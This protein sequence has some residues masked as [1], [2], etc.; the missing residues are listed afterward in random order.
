MHANH[1]AVTAAGR[2]SR[3][4]PPRAP[5]ALA[6]AAALTLSAPAT[7]QVA[8][9]QLPTSGS[10]AG[11]T[12]TIQAPSGATQVITQTSN[13]MALTWSSFDVGSA[14]TVR[15]DQPSSSAAVLNLIGGSSA[16]QIFGNLSANG[17]VFLINS[18]GVLFGNTAQVNV[19]GLVASSLSTSAAN[20]MSSNDALDAG[21]STAS[22]INSGTITAAAGSVN[23]IGGQVVNDGTITATAGNI[24]LA[25]ADRVTLN[26]EAGGFGVIITRA[27]QSQLA[28]LAVQNTG[29]LI[30]PGN[31][32]SLQASAASG[33][34]SQLINNSGI[35]SAASL[36][37]AGSDGSVSLVANGATGTAIGGSGSINADTGSIGYSAGAGGIE[38]TGVLTAGDLSATAGRDLLLTGSN[39]IAGIRATV[40]GNLSVTNARS[41]GQASALEVNG[42][43]TFALGSNALTLDN[44]GNNFTG[45]VNITAGTTRIDDGNALT[46]G[47][48]NTGNLTA[49]SNGALNL[50][51]GSV[52]GTLTAVSNNGAII[53]STGSGLT[54]T[55]TSNLQA[56]TGAITLTTGSND[57]QQAVTLGGGATSI[58]DANALTL[59]TLSTGDLTAT[60]TGALNLGSGTVTGTLAASS[61]NGAITQSTVSGLSVTGT[62]NLQAGTG[63]ITLTTGSNDFQQAVTLGGGATSITD[64]NALTLGTLSTGN[65]TANSTGALNLGSGTVNGN[66]TATSNN[67][68]ITQSTV[69]GL[70]VTGIGDVQAGTG[71]ITLTTGSNDFQQAVTLGGGATSITDG[72]A[73]TLGTLSTGNLTATS[74]GALN[75]GSGTVTGTLA[76]SSNNGAITQ[77]AVSGL[78]VTGTSNLQAGTGAITL[79]TGSNDFQQALTLGG[80]ATSITDGNALTLGTLSTGNLTAT[81]TGALNLGSGTVGGAL[82][83]VSNNG[84]I[85]QTGPLNVTGAG[86]INAGSGAIVLN[87]N[88]NDFAGGLGLTGGS[89]NVYDRNNLSITALTSGPNGAVELFSNAT[90]SLS[91]F[92][93]DTGT[94]LL[95][96]ASNGGALSTAGSLRGGTVSL[97]ARDGIGIGHDVDAASLILTTG[98]AAVNQTAGS[99]VVATSTTANTGSGA[100]TLSGAGNNFSGLLT[101]SAGNVQLNDVDGMSLGTVNTGALTVNGNGALN[102]GRGTINGALIANS[103]SGAITQTNALTVTG[104]S[105][106][107]AG[108]GTI[109][110]DNAGNDFQAAVSLTGNGITLR[111]ANALTLG[112]LTATGNGATQVLAGGT[113]TLPTQAIDTGT[114]DLSL[115]SLGGALTTAGTLAGNNVAL[116]ASGA[117]NLA[118]AIQAR[119]TL[120][121]ISDTAAITQTA[122][123]LDA[124]GATTATAAAGAGTIT[125]N[126]TNNDFQ[127]ALSLTGSTVLINDRNALNLGSLGTSALTVAS[128]GNLDLGQGT[129]GGTLTASSNGG[130]IGQSGALTLTGAATLDAGSGAIALSNSDN[131]FQDALALTGTGISVRDRNALR[132]GALTAGAG[133]DVALTAGGGLSLPVQAIDIGSGNLSLTADGGLLGT[134]GELRANQIRLHGG[135]GLNLAHDIT[136]ANSLTLTTNNAAIT[137]TAGAITAGALAAVDAGTGAIALEGSNNDFVA[138]LTLTGTGITVYDANDLSIAS[139]SSGSNSPVTLTA[140]RALSLPMQAIDTGSADLRLSSESGTLLTNGALSGRNVSLNAGA[141]MVL[142]HDVNTSGNLRLTTDNALIAQQSGKA[143]V[144]GTTQIVAG[145]GDVSLTSQ[146]NVFSD[147]VSVS[148]DQVQIDALGALRFGS[149]ATTTLTARSGGALNLG[150]GSTTGT[151]IARSGSGGITQT[152]AVTAGGAATMDAGSATIALNNANNDFQGAVGLAGNGIALTDRNT[153][154]ASS[155]TGNSTGDIALIAQTLNLPASAISAGTGTLSLTAT[156]G[157]FSTGGTLSGGNVVLDARDGLTLAHDI[158]AGNL[159]LRT[160]NAA[161]NQTGGQLTAGGAT[162]ANAG[163]AAIAL[164]GNND[165]QNAVTLTGGAV[166]INDRNALTLSAL[167]TGA[168]TVTSNG[169]LNL[170]QGT[171]NGAL[172]AN[173]TGGAITQT[174]ALNISGTSTLN[175]GGGAIT[176]NNANNDFQGAVGLTGNGIAVTDRNTLSVSSIIG[177]STGDIALTAQTL[178]LPASAISAGTGTLSLTAT[179]SAFSTG[180]N[181]SGGNVVLD[182]RDGLTLAHDINAGNLTLRTTNAAINQTAGQLSISGTTGA[183]AGAA[184]IALTGNNDFQNAVTLTGGAVQINDRNALTLSALNTGALTVTSNGALNLGQGTVNGVLVANSTGGAIT[185]TGALN[186]SGTST[187]NAGTG[188]ITLSNANNDFQGAVG[189]TGNGITVSDT[190]TLS[191]SSISGNTSGNIALTAQTLNLPASAISAGTGTLSLTA[192]A[193]ALGTNG[194]L[195]GGNVVLDAR[196]GLTL[197]NDISANNA[198]TLRTT[199]AAINQTAGQLLVGGATNANAG[200]AAIALTGN[201]DFQSAVTLTGGAVQLN[202]RNALTLG[203]VNT[204]ALTVTSN[205]ALNLGQ[206]T[207][208]GAL[209]A[210]SSNGAITQAGAL[211]INGTI[212]LNAGSSAITLNNA[213]NDFAGAV[214]VAGS[215]IALADRN[216]LQIV[217]L[218]S[219]GNASVLLDAGGALQLPASAIDVG[220]GALSLTARGSALTTTHALRGGDVQLSGANGIALGDDVAASGTLSLRSTNAAITQTAGTLQVA[221]NSVVDAGSGAITLNAAGNDFQGSLA[222]TGGATRVRDTNALSL[223]ALD[224]GALTVASNGALN[225]GF[226]LVDGDLDAASNGGAVTQTGAL[227]VTGTTRINSAGATI[228]LADAGNDFQSALSLSGGDTRVRDRNALALDTLDV[229]ALDVASG[230]GLNLGQGRIGGTLVARSGSNAAGSNGGPTAQAVVRPAATGAD[231]TQQ[232]A[233]TI[234]GNSR[235]DAGTAAIVLTD[236]GNDFQGSVQTSGGS[237]AL[238]DRNDLAAAAQSSGAVNL[239]AGGQLS[240]SGAISGSSVTLGSGGA[241]LLAHDITS[242]GTLSLRSGGAITQRAGSLRAAQLSGSAAGAATLTGAGNAIGTLGDFSAQGLDVFSATTLQVSGRVDGGSLLRLGS[243]GGLVLDGQ[244]NGATTWLQAAAG[245]RQRAGSTLTANLLG[246]TAGGPVAL[247]DAGSFIDNRVVRLGD[248]TASNGFSLTNAGDLTLVLSNGSIYSVDAGN[249]ALLLSVRGDLLQEGRAT[250]RDGTGSFSATGRIGTQQDPIYLIGTGTQTIGFVGAPPAYFNATTAGGGLLDLSGGSSFNVPASAFAGRAQSSASRTIAFVDLSASGTP[251]RAFGLVRPGLR[252]PDDQQ[253]ACDAGDPDAVCTPQ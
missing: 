79:T 159:T 48:L 6:L 130:T 95:Y 99:V 147:T 89:V 24:T 91:P 170:G 68:A 9:T 37:S 139:L 45:A 121:L 174:G 180:G 156:G 133:G 182:A 244:L 107:N 232:G 213:N 114:G 124:T 155:I 58:T 131:D 223:D 123:L 134:T 33:V 82:T 28:T 43:S 154:S 3:T 42:T 242:A 237:I 198:L 41:L 127:G 194:A 98:N 203:A 31:T 162:N 217:S 161:I 188:A 220:T 137:Q 63:A 178:N 81:S 192:T 148:G 60:S 76:A 22:I 8:S 144:D 149:F 214:S 4:L 53:Q 212:T 204:G 109:T 96:L 73:L 226:G 216:D 26:F 70:T 83:A 55:G 74:T 67:G 69:S 158:N 119:G 106:L 64:A 102:L 61:N 125:L 239:Q 175:A 104:A 184:A 101:L 146:S 62:S 21:G 249:A 19:G 231:I 46:L 196:D 56:G 29:S 207:V 25:G 78:S 189:L 172:V 241:T 143:D 243:G 157:T 171:V 208:N 138:Q 167:N 253:P 44:A 197:A 126:A 80:G 112:A 176:L 20:F 181:L 230:A 18:R 110:L 152:G 35:I 200:T 225:L 166:Q 234:V 238:A 128:H 173:S 201:N 122:G 233:L 187:L 205:G 202:D 145:S 219:G 227:T 47:T 228:A 51:S 32:I 140:G 199:N 59:G 168:L 105:T 245:I 54:V 57:F 150:Q 165:F 103:G 153:L 75:L 88:S 97:R 39:Q 251:Y 224:T 215:G 179:G 10:I 17:Q 229:G 193:S 12:G 52:G 222:L 141:G 36:S 71:A 248:F 92:A 113:L 115:T 186:I 85:G 206:G 177:N 142:R 136:A 49:T 169:A 23:L 151:L 240:S 252:L 190:N 160:T 14:A 15:F 221:G 120:G 93:I 209:I 211:D 72:N 11:G 90:L 27:L 50:G 84:A 77:S 163:T 185:Q 132:I 210:S 191:V 94:A 117:L 87:N 86:T 183:N 235:L 65:L 218:Q 195:S 246:G 135:S 16:S 38:Q 236:A 30:A 1:T 164:T 2:S 34:F 66:L 7:A 111:D 13:R 118:H 247:G 5:L 108:S 100:V 129:I 116:R 250:L 40:G